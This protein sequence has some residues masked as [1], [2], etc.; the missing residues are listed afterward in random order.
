[1]DCLADE[2]RV[3]TGVLPN[4]SIAYEMPQE[5]VRVFGGMAPAAE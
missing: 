4:R 3:L 1:M 5:S 2:R